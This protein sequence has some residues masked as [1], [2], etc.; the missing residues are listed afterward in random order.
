MRAPAENL[1]PQKRHL[2]PWAELPA[3]F[4]HGQ[5]CPGSQEEPRIIWEEIPVL[6]SCW[7]RA[8][9]HWVS[10]NPGERP[11][12]RRWPNVLMLSFLIFQMGRVVE[13]I[14][15]GGYGNDIILCTMLRNDAGYAFSTCKLVILFQFI[16]HQLYIKDHHSYPSHLIGYENK[17]KNCACP[18]LALTSLPWKAG[19]NILPS[20]HSQRPVP[21][22]GTQKTLQNNICGA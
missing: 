7:A 2:H 18:S 17:K 19:G 14:S 1:I 4:L 21:R 11:G 20:W 10:S 6:L 22:L 5:K 16:R 13:P 12:P 3:G 9:S 8:A 15:K